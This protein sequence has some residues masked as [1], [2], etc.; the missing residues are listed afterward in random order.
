MQRPLVFEEI[1]HREKETGGQEQHDGNVGAAKNEMSDCQTCA[2][3]MSNLDG[4]RN[5]AT[6][7]EVL[8]SPGLT[9]ARK[10]LIF[11]RDRIGGL[12]IESFLGRVLRSMIREQTSENG[13]LEF[14][15]SMCEGRLAVR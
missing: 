5:V 12:K 2:S 1:A 11:G 8:D 13:K 15:T 4:D 6:S 10:N 9:I 7:V 14:S 3:L